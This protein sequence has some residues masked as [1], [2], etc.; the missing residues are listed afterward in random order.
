[1]VKTRRDN[2]DKIAMYIIQAIDCLFK[3]RNQRHVS[4]AKIKHH[5][6]ALFTSGKSKYV[7]NIL[8]HIGGHGNR[9][10]IEAIMKNSQISC[11]FKDDKRFTLFISFDNIQSL[12]KSHRLT[13]TE[14]EKVYGVIVCSILALLP[15]GYEVCEISENIRH[16]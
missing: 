5:F 7:S 2:S 11:E 1:M 4:L 9:K 6:V 14:R 10:I 12:A 13:S 15:D 3:A 8:G 16:S